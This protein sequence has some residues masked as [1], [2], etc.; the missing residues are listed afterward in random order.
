MNITISGTIN[1][2]VHIV[3]YAYY[4]L[5]AFG[6][7]VQKYLWWKKHI[8][9]MQMVSYSYWF[10]PTQMIIDLLLRILDVGVENFLTFKESGMN[11]ENGRWFNVPHTITAC[12]LEMMQY[13]ANC[14]INMQNS[15]CVS[16]SKNE[17][18]PM[19]CNTYNLLLR[20]FS[21]HPLSLCL[22][23]MRK[24]LT[25]NLYDR[26]SQ[27]RHFISLNLCATFY[28]EFFFFVYFLFLIS[29]VFVWW[30]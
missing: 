5:S 8:T 22:T 4:L 19:L 27:K 3:M 7:K 17:E 24:C 20:W 21:I 18:K 10:D 13:L 6:P 1:S 26:F 14:L 29:Y 2:F 16:P 11:I 12:A 28:F 9:N 15:F 23:R 25:L 30:E